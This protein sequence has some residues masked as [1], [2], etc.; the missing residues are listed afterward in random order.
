MITVASFIWEAINISMAESDT[1]PTLHHRRTFSSP[2][3]LSYGG[4]EEPL[5]SC[6]VFTSS[7]Y[8]KF[9]VEIKCY[10]YGVLVVNNNNRTCSKW[11]I[12]LQSLHVTVQKQQAVHTAG[13][14]FIIHF[15]NMLFPFPISSPKLLPFPWE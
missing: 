3:G 1:Q 12:Q 2:E 8:M 7:W 15:Q 4:E 11:L 6:V 10:F 13:G 9:F 14:N 5:V